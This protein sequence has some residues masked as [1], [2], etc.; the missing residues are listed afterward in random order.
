MLIKIEVPWF[1]IYLKTPSL[2]VL[3]FKP[4]DKGEAHFFNIKTNEKLFTIPLD[5]NICCDNLSFI[6][7]GRPLMV[8]ANEDSF[9]LFDLEQKNALS[10]STDAH[11]KNISSCKFLPMRNQFLT[12]S[13]DNSIK[14][15]FSW[16]SF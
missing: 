1:F 11:S 14:V 10:I 2:D 8:V 15:F 16:K 12:T 3:I 6:D 5:I 13:D 4:K 9:E 7:D